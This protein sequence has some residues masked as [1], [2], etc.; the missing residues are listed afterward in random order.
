LRDEE[1]ERLNAAMDGADKAFFFFPLY[2]DQVPSGMIEFLER[3]ARHRGTSPLSRLQSI[4]ALCNS[5]FPEAQQNDQALAVIRRFTEL[6]GFR[7]LGGLALGGGGMVE[8]G[9]PL[10]EQGGKAARIRKALCLSADALA[11]GQDL[12]QE[13]VEGVR[14][15]SIPAF[16]YAWIAEVGFRW[17][18][19]KKKI[20]LRAKPYSDSGMK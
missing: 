12:P 4:G 19:W 15:M 18:C 11:G 3:Y 7:F 10:E 16:L 2:A 5:G 14:H 6:Q 1:S 20:N 13:A 9:K 8:A 17:E